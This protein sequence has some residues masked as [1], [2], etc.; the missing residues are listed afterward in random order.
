MY[1]KIYITI[2]LITILNI[3]IFNIDNI[4]A[5]SK[6]EK[7]IDINVFSDLP[8]WNIGEFWKYRIY[9]EGE[10]G[11]AMVFSWS[12]NNL[13]FTIVD[14]TVET[15][16]FEI[17]SDV[18]GEITLYDIQL[19]S[20]QLKDTTITGNMI[21]DKSNNGFQELDAVMQG[22]ISVINIPIKSFTIEL[23][24]NFNPSFSTINFPLNVGKE[25]EVPYSDVTGFVTISL[26]NNP[27][28]MDD[29][30]GGNNLG[31]I[32]IVRK[33]VQ[34]GTFDSYKIISDGDVQEIYY[35]ENAGNII[36][37]FGDLSDKID[38]ELKSTNYEPITGAPNKPTKP[39][40]PS[41]GTPGNTYNYTSYSIDNEGDDILYKFDWGDGVTTDWFGP[42]PSGQEISA[43]HIWN[44]RGNYNIRVRAKDIYDHE[45]KWSDPL[46][47]TMPKSLNNN[48]ILKRD[49]LFRELI[50]SKNFFVFFKML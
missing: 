17:S 39:K 31:C 6:K 30:V 35:A 41:S 34:A 9:Y 27:I 25:W 38:I 49:Y 3:F 36:K 29:L 47:V 37:A 16:I 44:S 45:S 26:L 5:N 2:I 46:L 10:F 21:V 23:D 12:F 13:L 19:I 33:S 20:G 24:F 42:Y 14:E 40:G 15:Y 48:I 18:S 8:I 22:K 50:F 32:E 11:E 1:K 28:L 4:N 43:S 7:T